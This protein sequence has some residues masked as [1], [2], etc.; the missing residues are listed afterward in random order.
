MKTLNGIF[1]IIENNKNFLEKTFYV[2]RIGIFGSYS[3]N[4]S[5]DKS[6]IDI[7]VE[8]SKKVDMFHFLK[9]ENFLS[10]ILSIKVDLVTFN[11]LRKE[12]KEDI[13][14]EVVYA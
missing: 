7:L 1:E 6:D 12:L 4:Y 10:D 13:L 14:R 11:A 2:S 9:L 5:T 8:F 3:K